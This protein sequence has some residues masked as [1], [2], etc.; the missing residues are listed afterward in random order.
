MVRQ[1][2]QPSGVNRFPA[3]EDQRSGRPREAEPAVIK[4]LELL[5]DDDLTILIDFHGM[6][7]RQWEETGENP[8]VSL[9]YHGQVLWA[10]LDE[11]ERR[12]KSPGELAVEYNK[13]RLMEAAWVQSPG[14][15]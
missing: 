4:F 10:L 11:C 9:I 14:H 6:H 8:R 7:F 13:R 15:A 3:I 2:L 12:G 1:L 5:S